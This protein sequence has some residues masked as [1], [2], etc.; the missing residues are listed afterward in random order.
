[1][2]KLWHKQGASGLHPLIESYTV[3]DDLQN[4]R[5]L[6]PYDL[7]ASRAHAAMLHRIGILSATELKQLQG[8]L[9]ELLQ[10][11]EEGK[12]VIRAQD[13]DGHTVIENH[14]IERL[15]EV[16]KKIHT[17]RSRN[18]QS[19][20]ALRLYLKEYSGALVLQVRELAEAFLD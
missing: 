13:E 18:D 9:D 6:F 16:G 3:G 20:V 1:M 12:V 14:L 2:T 11:W 4:D 17:G 8:G 15:G 5:I 7:A 10:L 19:L